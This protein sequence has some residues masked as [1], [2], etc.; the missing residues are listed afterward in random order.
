MVEFFRKSVASVARTEA[1]AD[2]RLRQYMVAILAAVLAVLVRGSLNKYLQSDHAFVISLLAVVASAWQGGFGPAFVT[3]VMSLLGTVYFFLEPRWTFAITSPSDQIAAGLF[4]FCGFVASLLGEA[5]RTSRRQAEDNLGDT[6]R[7]QAALEAE[8]TH[9]REIEVAL[10]SREAD[11][12][13]LNRELTAAQAQSAETF[14]VLD[15]FLQNAPVG[16]AFYDKQLR[17]VHINKCLADANQLPI[18]AHLGKT[19]REVMPDYPEELLSEFESVL[20]SGQAILNRVVTERGSETGEIWQLNLFPVRRD[21]ESIGLGVIAQAVTERIRT[22]KRLRDSEARY[23]GLT[24]A[25]PQMVWVADATGAMT[26]FNQRWV[27]Y[28]GITLDQGRGG[29]WM[30]AAH[31]DDLPGLVAARQAAF[32]G[33]TA[34]YHHE[35]R[36]RRTSDG[37]FRWMLAKAIPLRDDQGGVEWVGTLTDI[38]D[39][40]RSAERLEQMVRDRTLEL[41]QANELLRGEVEERG[42]AEARERA[43]GV[44][45][46]RSNQELEQFAYIASHDLQ[47]PLRKIQAFGDRLRLRFHEQLAEQG[48]DYIERMLSSAVRMRRLI[49]DL[50]LFSR[51]TTKPQA[52]VRIDLDGVLGGVLMDLEVGIE[53]AGAAIEVEPLPAIEADPMQMRQ[54]FQNL[55]GNALKFAAPENPPRIRVFAER[56]EA[57]PMDEG[58]ASDGEWWRISVQDNGIGFDEKYT[59]RIFQVF[60][61]LHGRDEYE[62]T[63]VG[64]AICRKIVE[65][66][67]GGIAARSQ[68]GRGATFNITLPA[69]QR[70]K[71]KESSHG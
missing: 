23:R 13:A 46:L 22:E 25:V 51:V 17:Y 33:R 27:D 54:L 62:G 64:L 52:L 47:E 29:G 67:G 69:I 42:Y 65:R 14:A 21:D 43:G 31:P 26:F 39:Q 37:A 55:I 68:P 11:L 2:H 48:R 59:D 60:Q 7:K 9:R 1:E 35:Y 28:T 50:L 24:Q 6:I 61:R 8:I 20:T 56:A 71:A 66:H 16:M 18:E 63:G 34:S 44:E 41:S 36:L 53:K 40:K 30:S 49:D 5:Q 19:P 38:D 3:L 15:A 57:P 4:F 12:L 10:R 58:R 45:L 70:L 32:E